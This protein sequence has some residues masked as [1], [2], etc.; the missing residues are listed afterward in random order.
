MPAK[1]LRSGVQIGKN[2]VTITQFST[3]IYFTA[4][5]DNIIPTQKAI[6]S[7]LAR[8]ISSGG[9]NAMTSVLT[10]GTVGVGPQSI[11]SASGG[12][13]NMNNNVNFKGGVTGTMLALQY[14]MQSPGTSD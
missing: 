9:A 6:K 14:F 2:T 4:N 8:L 11:F 1:F 5:S 13:I 3:D 12:T 7:Y 10:A